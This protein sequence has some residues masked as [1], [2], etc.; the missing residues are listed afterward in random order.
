MAFDTTGTADPDG[1]SDLTGWTVDYGEGSPTDGGSS[2]PPLTLNH[3]YADK[4]EYTAKL[5]VLD[6]TGAPFSTTEQ[7]TVTNSAPTAKL[8]P[9]PDSG[10]RDLEVSFST[11]GTTDP[12]GAGDLASYRLDF[13]DGT[14]ES[15]GDAPIPA[16]VSHTYTQKGTYTAKLT[17]VDADDDDDEDTATVTVTN[18][19]PVARLSAT[20]DSGPRDLDVVFDASAS[21]DADGSDDI[22]SFALDYGDGLTAIGSG[23]PP[24][25]LAHTYEAKG[26][27]T[28]ELLGHGRRRRP[29]PR[30]EDDHRHEHRAGR[31]AL[32][33]T[34][35]RA[36]RAERHV[37]RLGLQRR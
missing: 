13:G 12:D 25:S 35:Q 37:R 5:T 11:A 22:T 10:P 34:P 28:A 6:S 27:Y 29:G 3:T 7:I 16:T 30:D 33:R 19:P 9:L 36:P 18:S 14:S 21:S 8:T 17:I 32:R 4:G 15:L 24:A 31:G 2:A 23:A 26:T 20:P 1:V